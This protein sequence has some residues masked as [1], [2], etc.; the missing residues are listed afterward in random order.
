MSDTIEFVL[1]GDDDRWDRA[2]RRALTAIGHEASVREIR[3]GMKS[4]A[5][6]VEGRRRAPGERAE[7]GAA[8]RVAMTLRA[9]ATLTGD[10]ALA[11][12]I[13]RIYEDDELLV[14]AKPSG[15]PTTPIR[16]DETSGTLLH[17]AIAIAPA[18]AEAG[19]VLE[20]GAV[21]RLDT[22]TSGVVLFAKSRAT[23]ATLR[24]LFREHRVEKQYE[25]IVE[26]DLDGVFADGPVTV[27]A[28]I[29]NA[30]DHVRVRVPA[31][32]EVPSD[33]LEASTP[34]T[35]TDSSRGTNPTARSDA[36]EAVSIVTRTGPRRVR[37]TTRFGR[38]H[39]VRVH[40]AHLGLPILGD[41][42]YGGADAPRLALHA[43]ALVLPDGTA[44]EA[45]P[46]PDFEGLAQP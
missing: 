7:A 5:I 20:G 46:P 25:A 12:R 23:R 33:A 9:D 14:L 28:P 40:L 16:A 1:E 11:A 45:P 24:Q 3:A 31:G 29:A 18:I 27:D 2:I 4:G 8:I 43:R 22:A 15:V 6:T 13:E 10:D 17:A 39:Q 26:G 38:R 36:L 21:H 30:G 19:P 42:M 37:V 34:E 35:A 44:F 32:D 41:T